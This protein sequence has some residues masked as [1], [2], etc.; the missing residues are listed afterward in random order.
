[1]SHTFTIPFLMI[2]GVMELTSLNL[3]NIICETWRRSLRN[4]NLG[5]QEANAISMP[6]DEQPTFPARGIG[7]LSQ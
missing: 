5:L 7:E 6:S 3:L 2:S 4:P 1:M